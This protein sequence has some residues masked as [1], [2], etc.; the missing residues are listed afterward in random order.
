MTQMNLKPVAQLYNVFYAM[1]GD[2]RM[3]NVPLTTQAELILEDVATE[4]EEVTEEEERRQFVCKSI[5]ICICVELCLKLSVVWNS[6]L[7]CNLCAPMYQ[8]I[9]C[10]DWSF[11][12]YYFNSHVFYCNIFTS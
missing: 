11:K 8:T 2:M 1:Y 9:I 5:L 6:I 10:L 3:I 4:E 7:I 12:F